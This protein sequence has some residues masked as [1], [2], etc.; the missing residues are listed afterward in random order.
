MVIAIKEAKYLGDYRIQISFSDGK[1]RIID[2]EPFLKKALNPMTT[3]F[4]DKTLFADFEI[5]HGDLMWN[6]FEMCF[7]IWDLYEGKV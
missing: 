2:F 1:E 5:E 4:L 3:K 7:P 6:D